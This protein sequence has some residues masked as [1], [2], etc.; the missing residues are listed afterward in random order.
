[1][2]AGKVQVLAIVGGNPVYNAPADLE[3]AEELTRSG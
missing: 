2:N 1:M 3:F